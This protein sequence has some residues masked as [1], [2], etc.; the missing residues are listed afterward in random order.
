MQIKKFK[1]R[2]MA[3]ALRKVKKEFGDQAVI[4]SAK[5]LKPA[6]GIFGAAK[7]KRVEITAA[8]DRFNAAD[9]KPAAT[10]STVLPAAMPDPANPL[11]TELPVKTVTAPPAQPAANTIFQQTPV[12][13]ELELPSPPDK[14]VQD[15]PAAK[16][17]KPGAELAQFKRALLAQDI[18]TEL[19]TRMAHR[20]GDDGDAAETLASEDLN[21]RFR[22][23]LKQQLNF[24]APAKAKNNGPRVVALV[25]PTGVG[26]TTTT[27]KLAAVAS[28]RQGA[29]VGLISLDHQRIGGTAQLEVLARVMDL[30]LAVI[31][32]KDDIKA[33]LAAMQ[34]LDIILVDTPGVSANRTRDLKK[35]DQLIKPLRPDE[36]HLLLSA[37]TK[38][39]DLH[40]L[41]E[42]FN[43]VG[44]DRLIFTK[45]DETTV[46]GN[47]LNLMTANKTPLAYLTDGPQVPEG[48]KTATA[49]AVIELFAPQGDAAPRGGRGAE[50][51]VTVVQTHAASAKLPAVQQDYFVAN[52]NSDIFHQPDCKAVKRINPNNILVFK[53]MG[54]AKSQ[55][56]KPCRMCCAMRISKRPAFETFRSKAVG[57]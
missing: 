12:Y 51:K 35:L 42:Q 15:S 11:G 46:Y 23:L 44:Y 36:T 28:T 13:P 43:R 29:S 9:Q 54:E 1:A 33:A 40:L 25:G 8:S 31:K 18:S 39:R 7:R 49:E 47:L 16:T 55:N 56:F 3:T 22:H 41:A 2:D 48:L 50:K 27:A 37:T 21:S 24:A 57:G 45:L 19:A 53:N 34:D 14:P 10:I 26:K 30:P 4:L 6:N 38:D 52:R 5:T 17:P 20:I 32:S